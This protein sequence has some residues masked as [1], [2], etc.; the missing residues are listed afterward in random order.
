[1]IKNHLEGDLRILINRTVEDNDVME[2]VK[3]KE[4]EF[5]SLKSS[6]IERKFSELVFCTLT[7][8]TSAEMGLRCQ[9][10]L[11]SIENYSMQNVREKLI[12][13]KYRFRNTRARYIEHNRKKM[14][15]LD[16]FLEREDRREL[17]VENY[18]GIGMKEASH[19]LRNIGYFQ[20]SILDKHIQRFLSTYYNE[21][22]RIRNPKDYYNIERKF[23]IL[24]EEYG[25][26]PGIMDL[27]IWYIMTG[28]II[29]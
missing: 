15:L 26:P 20:Y 3:I 12:E 23:I 14:N 21:N 22:I 29:K 28:K 19:F 13:C 7:A 1:M 8:N 16:D 2:M 10:Y 24:S 17:L 5:L 25:F 18:M 4:R 27:I 9:E 6:S 11:Q